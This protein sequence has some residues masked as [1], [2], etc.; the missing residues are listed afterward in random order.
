MIEP[1][2]TKLVRIA[3]ERTNGTEF[4][5]FADSFLAA[6]LGPRYVPMSGLHDGGADWFIEE[7]I[8]EHD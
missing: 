1:P 2:D 4:Q 5:S 7:T 8:Y 6:I 3:L